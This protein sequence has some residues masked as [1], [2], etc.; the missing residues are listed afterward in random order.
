MS[1]DQNEKWVHLFHHFSSFAQRY[2]QKQF[3]DTCKQKCANTRYI[4]FPYQIDLRLTKS[5]MTIPLARKYHQLKKMYS[6]GFCV[7]WTIVLMDL[8]AAFRSDEKD[9]VFILTQKLKP[10]LHS[11]STSL[12]RHGEVPSSFSEL[13][14]FVLI[15]TDVVYTISH[16]GLLLVNFIRLKDTYR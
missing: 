14:W 8:R 2:A 7:K 1:K 6:C 9:T 3:T 16:L 13:F 12:C 4:P 11:H 15:K 5:S 10:F